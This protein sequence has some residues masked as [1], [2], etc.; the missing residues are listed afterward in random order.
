MK[1]TTETQ[2]DRIIRDVNFGYKINRTMYESQRG[3]KR[4]ADFRSRVCD[5]QKKLGVRFERETVPGKRYK[6]YWLKR[7]K[8]SV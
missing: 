8:F 6:Q 2:V 1:D 3:K 7:A 5:A 4:I